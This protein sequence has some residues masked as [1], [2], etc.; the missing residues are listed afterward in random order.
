MKVILGDICYPKAES[1]II[2]ANTK[3]IMSDSISA[4]ISKVGLGSISKEAKQIASETIIDLT[5]C[6]VTGSGRLNRRGV[7]KI[8]HSVIK[9]LQ[10][11]FT[12]IYT[13]R[14]ALKKALQEVVNNRHKSVA[15]SA[16]G[17]GIG[18]IDYKILAG[19]IVGVCRKFDDIIEIKI[20]NDDKLFIDEV[21]DILGKI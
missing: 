5:D 1:L 18:G 20:I 4:R 10:S 17:S 6:I 15:V 19:T 13:I 7:K 12:S 8:Y 14:E 16:L 21:E 9:K 2:P 11:D 3:G